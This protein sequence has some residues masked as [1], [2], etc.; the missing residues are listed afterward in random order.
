[1][2]RLLDISG[3]VALLSVSLPLWVCIILAIRVSTR[4]PAFFSQQRVGKG[5][6]EFRLFKFRTL[7]PGSENSTRPVLPG[8]AR[9]TSVGS[10]LRSTHLDELPQLYNVL[11]GDMSLVGPRPLTRLSMSAH[12]GSPYYSY[13]LSVR[14][15]LTGLAQIKGRMWFVA[16]GLENVFRLDAFYIKKS[17][18]LFD[19]YILLKTAGMLWRRRGI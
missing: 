10:F 18:L 1:M 16:H 3:A 14:P 2:K 19:L 13:R 9:V 7:L 12:A 8:D 4:G 6:K 17:C 5:G 15:G 11:R